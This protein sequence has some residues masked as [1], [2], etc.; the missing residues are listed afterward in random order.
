MKKNILFNLP[1]NNKERVLIDLIITYALAFPDINPTSSI[2]KKL[3]HLLELKKSINDLQGQQVSNIEISLDVLED[4]LHYSK[5]I[6]NEFKSY[7]LSG[8]S[9]IKEFQSTLERQFP[10]V[11]EQ[12][13]L[14]L[15]VLP[16]LRSL[17]DKL[18]MIYD[19][20]YEEEIIEKKSIINKLINLFK[21]K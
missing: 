21:N 13:S 18:T 12:N 1:L 20:N 16:E 15:D 5:G 9:M 10:Q 11:K 3:N 14:A 17:L 4:L 6:T 7:S 2:N 19:A 8:Q